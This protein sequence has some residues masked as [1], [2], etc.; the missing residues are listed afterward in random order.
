[1]AILLDKNH[2]GK[3]EDILTT[4]KIKDF[5]KLYHYSCSGMRIKQDKAFKEKL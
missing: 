2:G 1:M 3:L 4:F 5:T